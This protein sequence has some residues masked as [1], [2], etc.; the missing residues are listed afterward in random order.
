V[1]TRRAQTTPSSKFNMRLLRPAYLPETRIDVERA[2]PEVPWDV[3]VIGGGNAGLIASIVAR[4]RRLK[5]LLLEAAPREF[6]AGNTRHTRNIRC[7]HSEPTESTAGRYP[8]DELYADLCSVGNGPVNDTLARLA[9]DESAS[10]IK[11]MNQH[12]VRWQKP[13]K[14]TLSLDRTNHFFLGGGKALA[15]HYYWLAERLGVVIEYGSKVIEIELAQNAAQSVIV[16][17][18]E[19]RRRVAARAFILACGGF[20]ANIEWLSRYWGSAATNF[21]IRGSS[22]NDGTVLARM[23][24]AGAQ[25]AGDAKGFHAV[26]VDARSPKF[27]GGIA[28]RL[29]SIPFGIVVNLEGQRFADEGQDIWPKRYASW[30]QL[31]ASQPAQTAVSIYDSKTRGLF[32]P[33]LYPPFQADSLADLAAR[34][35]L[36]SSGLEAT[37]LGFNAHIRQGQQFDNTRADG[38]TTHDL[39]P[40]KSNWA[41]PVDAPPYFA[42]PLRPGITFT[43]LGLAVDHRSRVQHRDSRP[44]QNVYAA[45]EIMAGN[46]LSSGYLA[47]FGMAIGSVFGRLAGIEVCAEGDPQ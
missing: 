44:F 7:A 37:V 11:W 40:A 45:G 39:V 25:T 35:N 34:V 24:D 2:H 3:V 29:D 26:A 23:I 12:G 9:V 1:R 22:F 36:P 19:N 17:S 8:S 6:R 18:G 41:L 31:I 27:D 32:I 14:G 47:G 33:S 15:N 21:V 4:E 42:I 38:C 13:L 46:I 43:Y 10:I 20:E 28:T 5:V 16:E 30:G